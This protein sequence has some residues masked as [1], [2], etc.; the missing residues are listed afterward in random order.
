MRIISGSKRGKVLATPSDERIRP[1]TDR[2]REALFSI[3]QSKI[4]D[5]L[6]NMAVLDIFSGTGAL[7]LEAASRG[8]KSVAFVD[9][10][11]RLTEKNAKLCGFNNLSFIKR[12]ARNLPQA[13]T[14]YDLIFLDAPYHMGLSEPTLDNLLKQGYVAKEALVIVETAKDEKLDVPSGMEVIDERIY[15][16]A[17]FRFLRYA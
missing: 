17:K 16:A 13:R 14:V 11:L 9:I 1:T 10:D 7:G 8:A 2:A 4:G 6:Q 12:D 3:I 15:G 5:E